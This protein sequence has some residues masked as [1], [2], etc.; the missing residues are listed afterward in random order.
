MPCLPAYS[1]F[2]TARRRWI[3]FDR[4]SKCQALK[5]E[6]GLTSARVTALSRI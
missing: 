2:Y 6:Y 3:Q 1:T 4:P 5:L